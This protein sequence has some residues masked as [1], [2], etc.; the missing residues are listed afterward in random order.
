MSFGVLR[1]HPAETK[2]ILTVSNPDITISEFMK[3][4]YDEQVIVNRRPRRGY[5]ISFVSAWKF[6]YNSVY[7]MY[8][9]IDIRS[10]IAM[11]MCICVSTLRC[12]VTIFVYICVFTRVRASLSRPMMFS[13]FVRE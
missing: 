5:K 1:L 12:F 2:N 4:I 10:L 11:Y 9:V 7:I 6:S 13:H 8:Y 3:C